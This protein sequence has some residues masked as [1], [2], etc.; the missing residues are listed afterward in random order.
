MSIGAAGGRIGREIGNEIDRSVQHR[1][2]G[3]RRG[4]GLSVV[5][6]EVTLRD[7]REHPHGGLSAA[8]AGAG[9]Y[10]GEIIAQ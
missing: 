8:L 2:W 10:R 1:I 3:D 4:R 5:E 6:R 9:G 7:Q